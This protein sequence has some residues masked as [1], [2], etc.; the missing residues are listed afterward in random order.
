MLFGTTNRLKTAREI[1]VLYNNQIINFT[2]T[3]KYLGNTVDH[4]LNF[5]ENCE[6]SYKKASS[7]LRLL[8]QMRCYPTSKAA[9]LVYIT[10]IT[11]LL[12]SSCTLKSPYNNTQKLKYNSLD[13]WARKI[14]KL[15]VP[16]IEN[17]A[18]RERVLVKSCLC[19]ESNE[20]FNNYFKLIEH[21]YETRNNS[22]SIKLPHVKLE[23]AKQCFYFSGGVLY[24]SLPIEI[25][26]TNG[27]GKFKELV[28]AHFS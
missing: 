21:K 20:E 4:Y 14:I 8:E 18:N 11:P 13:R 24:N 3:Y 12:T 1:D 2:E 23:L 10:M 7:R 27:Y 26:D 17:L 6:K 22:K 25:R 28:K 16:S 5:S 19:K 9:R 15:N